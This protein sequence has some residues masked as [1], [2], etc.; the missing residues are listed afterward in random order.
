M[1]R[2]RQ[3]DRSLE[4]AVIDYVEAVTL[5]PLVGQRFRAVVTD[6]NDE[7]NRARVQLRSPAVVAHVTTDGLTLGDDVALR[8]DDA[9][10]QERTVT[11]SV[12]DVA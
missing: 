3:R 8:L 4:R 6:V 1:G 7:R 9:D 12:I 10:P 11:F 5:M 2:A